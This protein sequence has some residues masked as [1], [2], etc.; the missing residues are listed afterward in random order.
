MIPILITVAVV[1]FQAIKEEVTQIFKDILADL[2]IIVTIL[3]FC[4]GQR[5]ELSEDKEPIM[6]ANS[7]RRTLI[8]KDTMA[9]NK[10]DKE[11]KVKDKVLLDKRRST[12]NKQL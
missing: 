5:V 12:N 2:Q 6:K 9:V 7:T 11:E 3:R 10:L 1:I 8:S 4:R